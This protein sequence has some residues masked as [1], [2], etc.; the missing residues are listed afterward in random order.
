MALTACM[1]SFVVITGFTI[2]LIPS[3]SVIKTEKLPRVVF[4]TRLAIKLPA[5]VNSRTNIIMTMPFLMS[6]FLFFL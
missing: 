1:D 3:S 4:G 6:R 5:S 2:N